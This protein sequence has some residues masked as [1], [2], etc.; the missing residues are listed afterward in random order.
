MDNTQRIVIVV[1][2]ILVVAVVYFYACGSGKADAEPQVE[3]FA[4]DQYLL[5]A[6]NYTYIPTKQCQGCLPSARPDFT[7]M[8]CGT[9]SVP[10][11][12]KGMSK[13]QIKQEIDLHYR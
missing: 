7:A 3:N 12:L 11:A 10:D 9:N 8:T 4:Y 2:I 5:N 13:E 1:G 6:K